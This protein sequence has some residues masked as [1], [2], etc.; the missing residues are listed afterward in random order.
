MAPNDRPGCEQTNWKVRGGEGRP[1]VQGV[2]MRRRAVPVREVGPFAFVQEWLNRTQQERRHQSQ[3][4]YF[5]R[6]LIQDIA[7]IRFAS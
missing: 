5:L 2:M 4:R 3:V 7:Y 1:R 6:F